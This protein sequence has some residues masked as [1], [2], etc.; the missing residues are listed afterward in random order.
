MSGRVDFFGPR[1]NVG[2]TSS[3]LGTEFLIGIYQIPAGTNGQGA[4]GGFTLEDSRID[5]RTVCL[6]NY[7]NASPA[8]STIVSTWARIRP[9]TVTFYF[10]NTSSVQGDAI[11]YYVV[12]GGGG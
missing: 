8:S 1:P 12:L 3:Y 5:A 9:Q 7:L 4:L 6:A 10:N 11:A 2:G